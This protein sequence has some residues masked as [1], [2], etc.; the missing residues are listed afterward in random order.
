MVR[1]TRKKT[2]TFTASNPVVHQ[3]QMTFP[4]FEHRDV[5]R[6]EQRNANVTKPFR[7][8]VNVRTRETNVQ[9]T[10]PNSHG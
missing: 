3:T 7:C 10:A 8:A 9:D 5:G 6:V 1:E 4:H 2:K